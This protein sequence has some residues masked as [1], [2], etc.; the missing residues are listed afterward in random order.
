M[1]RVPVPDSSSTPQGLE[2]FEQGA[3]EG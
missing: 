2:L 1:Q 3:Y